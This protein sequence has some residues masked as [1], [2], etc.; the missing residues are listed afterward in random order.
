MVVKDG[1]VSVCSNFLSDNTNKSNIKTLKCPDSLRYFGCEDGYEGTCLFSE[2]TNL[3]KVELNEG[4]EYIHDFAFYNCTALSDINFPDSVK[5]VG[6]YAFRD[7]AWY[8][9]LPD[10][11]VYIGKVYYKY[12][13]EMTEETTVTIK[14]GTYCISGRAFSNGAYTSTSNEYDKLVA[15]NI[16]D[17]VE[18]IADGAFANCVGLKSITL[19]KNLTYLG[20]QAFCNCTSLEGTV[21]VPAGVEILFDEVFNN[22]NISEL[23]FAE[24]SKLKYLS[25]ES[26][27]SDCTTWL[28]SSVERFVKN[29]KTS[30]DALIVLPEDN[31]LVLMPYWHGNELQASG[32]ICYTGSVADYYKYGDFVAYYSE[33]EPEKN[34]DGTYVGVA[35]D[36]Y[37]YTG[38]YWHYDENGKPVLW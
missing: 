18:W 3:T 21:V 34:P 20:K 22:T 16:P 23:R 6:L 36:G 11:D 37:S 7:T 27:P 26:I 19:P 4:L 25:N 24:G 8:N 14:D 5:Y 31:N 38:S 35:Y 29:I 28:P 10:G 12:K 30:G 2:C 33:E 15:V 13:G 1:T 9:S 17:S 32:A